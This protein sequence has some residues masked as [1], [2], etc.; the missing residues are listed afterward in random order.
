M[1]WNVDLVNSV[2]FVN[3]TMLIKSIPLST[4]RQDDCVVWGGEHSDIYSVRNGYQLLLWLPILQQMDNRLFKQIWL[5]SCPPKIR[6]AMW[7][8]LRFFLP[9]KLCL[10][11]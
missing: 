3:E 9:T 2:F 10:Y 7:K 8:F 4:F 1:A 5:L 11:K 6:I